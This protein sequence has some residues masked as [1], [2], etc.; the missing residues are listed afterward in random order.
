MTDDRKLLLTNDDTK[1][2]TVSKLTFINRNELDDVEFTLSAKLH[3]DYVNETAATATEPAKFEFKNITTEYLKILVIINNRTPSE[4][5]N[6]TSKKGV[7]DNISQLRVSTMLNSSNVKLL[8]VGTEYDLTV[9]VSLK[10]VVNDINNANPD[11]DRLNVSTLI[12]AL[13]NVQVYQD[14]KTQTPSEIS[15]LGDPLLQ[16]QDYKVNGAPSRVQVGE[17]TTF[18]D[19]TNSTQAG[20]VALTTLLDKK[21]FLSE[22]LGFFDIRSR[23]VLVCVLYNITLADG[24]NLNPVL[25]CF[26]SNID[27]NEP[28]FADY[29]DDNTKY[30]ID[31]YDN[32]TLFSKVEQ[33]ITITIR[34]TTELNI[35]QVSLNNTRPSIT[36]QGTKKQTNVGSIKFNNTKLF[37]K[38]DAGS[39]TVKP[40]GDAEQFFTI[41]DLD[42]KLRDLLGFNS[43]EFKLVVKVDKIGDNEKALNSDLLT[44]IDIK[45]TEGN[46][47]KESPVNRLATIELNSDGTLP[48]NA[49][50]IIY[51]SLTSTELKDLKIITRNADGS[52]TAPFNNSIEPPTVDT[53]DIYSVSVNNKP[54]FILENTF[55]DKT[56]IE[57]YKVFPSGQS[58]LYT[59]VSLEVYSGDTLLTSLTNNETQNNSQ[60]KPLTL[61]LP[62]VAKFNDKSVIFNNFK[63]DY[64]KVGTVVLSSILNKPNNVLLSFVSV[65][66]ASGLSNDPS[67]FTVKVNNQDPVDSPVL[68]KY[69]NTNLTKLG[70]LTTKEKVK[71][72]LEFIAL[73]K[74]IDLDVS[75][76]FYYPI[77]STEFLFLTLSQYWVDASKLGKPGILTENIDRLRLLRLSSSYL[78]EVNNDSESAFKDLLVNLEKGISAIIK[79]SIDNEKTFAE[80][81]DDVKKTINDGLEVKENAAL[82]SKI[83][84]TSSLK[85]L[86]DKFISAEAFENDEVFLIYTP[87][88][89]DGIKLD[90]DANVVSVFAYYTNTKRSDT[91]KSGPNDRDYV[92]EY[93]PLIE[94]LATEPPTAK[95]DDLKIQGDNIIYGIAVRSGIAKYNDDGKVVPRYNTPKQYDGSII[96]D[97]SEI[98]LGEDNKED[99]V[100]LALSELTR[101]VA[102]F[103][104]S[105]SQFIVS[106]EVLD[107][108]RSFFDGFKKT[109]TFDSSLSENLVNTFNNLRNLITNPDTSSVSG[110]ESE[111]YSEDSGEDA[112]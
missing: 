68:V 45:V 4:Q 91:I 63:N 56:E 30:V 36:T 11:L 60:Q 22:R 82:L 17:I 21:I 111:S 75:K 107:N 110:S 10:D 70:T 92:I 83:D 65:R 54:S 94:D 7:F 48:E 26:Q 77:S 14:D 62:N 64:S 59:K 88:G 73:K 109:D 51:N 38:L 16:L 85:T 105:G 9:T 39:I 104:T 84:V 97:G 87:V 29:E 6:I 53:D 66:K 103:G 8:K 31:T 25:R 47:V 80:L 35:S 12:G 78:Q 72:F 98:T 2:L 1:R 102:T 13:V 50:T 23:N 28:A 96:L 3:E 49:D 20:K 93:G 71:I 24:S 15:E 99:E 43:L 18:L 34:S 90:N 100:I 32:L 67:N 5:V 79:N 55:D 108:L 27:T 37:S 19:T 44:P 106:E 95:I 61:L 81:V 42:D 58:D 41:N 74:L 76:A 112:S 40:I 101:K 69:D 57:N 33:T 52:I 89:E 86:L 46:V